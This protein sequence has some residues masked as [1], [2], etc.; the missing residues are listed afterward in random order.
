MSP[1]LPRNS[2]CA[3]LDSLRKQL[4]AAG[5]LEFDKH[6]NNKMNNRLRHAETLDQEQCDSRAELAREDE[7]DD[8]GMFLILDEA[9]FL[10]GA[11]AKLEEAEVVASPQLQDA[12]HCRRVPFEPMES[13]QATER[14]P[15]S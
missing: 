3:L 10:E 11:P 4:S 14:D 13:N 15:R 9:V 6:L 5:R 2:F 8:K 12:G 1:L 7:L